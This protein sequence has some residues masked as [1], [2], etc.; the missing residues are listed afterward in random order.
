MQ[1]HPHMIASALVFVIGYAFRFA[2]AMTVYSVVTAIEIVVN[3]AHGF[4]H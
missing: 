2:G 1:I 4:I 3:S